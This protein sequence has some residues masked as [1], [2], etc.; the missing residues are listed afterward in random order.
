MDRVLTSALGFEVLFYN[1]LRL[2]GVWLE[3]P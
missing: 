3:L 2:H 1:S